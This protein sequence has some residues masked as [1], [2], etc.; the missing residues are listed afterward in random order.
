MT[1]K[2]DR[3]ISLADQ[4]ARESKSL[5]TMLLKRPEAEPS[6]DLSR[7]GQIAFLNMEKIISSKT[8]E[9]LESLPASIS[10]LSNSVEKL[11][12]NYFQFEKRYAARIQ[13]LEAAMTAQMTILKRHEQLIEEIARKRSRREKR[14]PS[15]YN[16]F[17]KDKMSAGMSMVDAV[18]AWK[19]KEGGSSSTSSSMKQPGQDWQSPSQQY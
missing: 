18:K 12:K 2:V 16:L 17:L 7:K 14:K 15:E 11:E 8:I 13:K 4:V 6:P 9:K 5:R 10:T 19:E 3:A 1:S